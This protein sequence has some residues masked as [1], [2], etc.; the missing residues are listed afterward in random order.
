MKIHIGSAKAIRIVTHEEMESL[1]PINKLS[2]AIAS[3]GRPGRRVGDS[4]AFL[5]AHTGTG[6]IPR[7]H[8]GLNPTIIIG[9]GPSGKAL[10][11]EGLASI[12]AKARPS[13]GR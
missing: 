6:T 12:P 3:Y 11:L 7:A 2:G 4:L 8:D 13:T 9:P 10:V 1:P 5:Q